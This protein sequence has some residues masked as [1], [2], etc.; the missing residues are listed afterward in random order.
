MNSLEKIAFYLKNPKYLLGRS[1]LGAV[2]H[3]FTIRQRR[4]MHGR[5]PECPGCT[6]RTEKLRAEGADK[7]A[8]A[9]DHWCAFSEF[10]YVCSDYYHD[11]ALITELLP[12]IRRHPSYVSKRFEVEHQRDNI[13]ATVWVDRDWLVISPS[14]YMGDCDMR[15]CHG[16]KLTLEE[17]LKVREELKSEAPPVV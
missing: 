15:W 14:I 12:L 4:R 9:H 3:Y 7:Q 17:A 16:G 11:C 10:G 5:H 6:A 2:E 8:I 13:L 1:F